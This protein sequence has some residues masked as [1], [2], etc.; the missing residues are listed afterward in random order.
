MTYRILE[1][2]QWS[3]PPRTWS[4]ENRMFCR[5]SWS[6][7]I[8][9]KNLHC[10]VW[11]NYSLDTNSLIIHYMAE[12]TDIAKVLF[13]AYNEISCICIKSNRECNLTEPSLVVD[14]GRSDFESE[15]EI[16]VSNVFSI[17]IIL[18]TQTW[19]TVYNFFKRLTSSSF[20]LQNFSK[21]NSIVCEWTFWYGSFGEFL[22]TTLQNIL[23]SS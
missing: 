17:F 19:E 21:D 1:Y 4:S 11:I 15:L 16:Q 20:E 9:I 8:Y 22:R 18:Q 23:K 3:K 14:K 5:S 7:N 12:I 13:W 6:H 2:E 10:K